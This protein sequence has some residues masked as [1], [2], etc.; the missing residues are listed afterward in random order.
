MLTAR[1]AFA[2]DDVS[3]TLASVLAREPDWTLLPRDLSP[4][5]ATYLS[6]C[7]HKDP[8]QRIHDIADG[9]AGAGW[10]VR[11]VRDR[12][13]DRAVAARA[14]SVA[15]T[16]PRRDRERE[17]RRGDRRR[18]SVDAQAVAAAAGHAIAFRAAAKPAVQRRLPSVGGDLARRLADG[19]RR[20]LPPLPATPVGTRGEAYRRGPR[21]NRDPT[22]PRTPSSRRTGIGSAYYDGAYK[23]IAV[24]GGS[25]VTLF[26]GPAP[27]GMTWSDDDFIV[28]GQTQGI[29]RVAANGGTPEQIVK[30]ENNEIAS[31]PQMLPGSRAVLFTVASSQMQSVPTRWDAARIVVQDLE[32]GKTHDHRRGRKPRTLSPNR[33]YRV[34]DRR[35]AVCRALRRGSIGESR[36]FGPRRRRRQAK[37]ERRWQWIGVLQFLDDRLVGVRAG[38]GV[39]MVHTASDRGRGSE[40]R[41]RD[42][43][44]ASERVWIASY[45]SR[46]TST[47]VRHRRRKRCQRLDL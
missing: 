15:A 39:R 28:V 42:A 18:R 27:M 33:A 41:H 5:L 12:N 38:T 9:T 22:T 36:R 34:H 10:C 13:G 25:V 2:G 26:Q 37:Y 30:V 6:R 24:E 19:L 32:S 43:L 17:S 21:A 16:G 40:R 1:R 46:R 31:E 29:L 7:L 3:E 11:H 45:L 23:K 4:M 8:R 20:E 14:P 35:D 44:A 47:R